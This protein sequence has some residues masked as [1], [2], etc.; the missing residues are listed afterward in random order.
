VLTDELGVQLVTTAA[1]V[2]LV[3]DV[4]HTRAAV[5]A[6]EEG[7]DDHQRQ[8]LTLTD[9]PTGVLFVVAGRC[10]ILDVCCTAV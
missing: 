6:Q 1:A 5:A 8:V 4:G 7:H 9:S 2:D 10:V 3:D